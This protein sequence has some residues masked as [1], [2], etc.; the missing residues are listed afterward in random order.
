MTQPIRAKIT[1]T[2]SYAPPRRMTN[3]DLEALVDT[4]DQWIRDRTGIRE[5]RIADDSITCSDMAAAAAR[6]AMEMAHCAPEDVDVIVDATI[7]PDY[8][9][10]SNGCLVQEKLGLVNAV[11]FDVVAACTGFIAGLAIARGFIETG[12]YR[13]VVVIGSERLSSLTNW[14]D[15]TTCVLFGDAAGAVVLEP[16]DDGSGVLSTFMKSDGRMCDW[17]QVKVGGT[18]HPHTKEFAWDG[19]DKIAMRGADVFKV[20]VKEMGNACMRVLETAGVKPEDVSLVVPHQ[21]NMRIIE[22]L[23]KRLGIAPDKVVANVDRYGNTSSASVPLALD[24]LNRAGRIKP[25]DLVLMTA[26][27][28]GLIWGSVLVRW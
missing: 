8:P 6:N 27:G 24:E 28:G 22:A 3:V 11:A 17:L 16:A 5:R 2:G 1:G 10:P 26:F 12:M 14:S 21:A 9:L 20:A 13:K 4:T 15:R 7:T 23:I 19:S 18:R 25:G